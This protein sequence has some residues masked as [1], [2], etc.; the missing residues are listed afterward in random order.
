MTN[1]E[2]KL[3][4][5]GLGMIY[6]IAD[7]IAQRAIGAQEARD[8]LSK[9][10]RSSDTILLDLGKKHPELIKQVNEDPTC[11]IKIPVEEPEAK[12]NA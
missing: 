3:L 9:A 4:I 1:D 10:R 2:R 6:L 8:L 11:P 5:Q 7:C 12:P